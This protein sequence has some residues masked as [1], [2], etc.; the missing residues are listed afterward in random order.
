MSYQFTRSSMAAM[1]GSVACC[2]AIST[3][4]HAAGASMPQTAGSPPLAQQAPTATGPTLPTSTA[5]PAQL[6]AAEAASILALSTHLDSVYG[7][8]FG[9]PADGMLSIESFVPVP[10]VYLGSMDSED[11]FAIVVDIK[12]GIEA[13]TFE[14][15]MTL[16][17]IRGEVE[18][19]ALV[20]LDDAEGSAATVIPLDPANF[21]AMQLAAAGGAGGGGANQAAA[22]GQNP[23][24]QYDCQR[25]LG[26][27]CE[28]RRNFA[29]CTARNTHNLRLCGI[30][31]TLQAELR[32]AW[33]DFI[34]C[35]LLDAELNALLGVH[36]SLRRCLERGSPAAKLGCIV[37]LSGVSL[38]AAGYCLYRY[39]DAVADAED[40]AAAS[41]EREQ[42][43]YSMERAAIW[44]AYQNCPGATGDPVPDFPR[45]DERPQQVKTHVEIRP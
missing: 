28:A 32:D 35:L 37:F 36:V 17:T 14:A 6:A 40:A 18:T 20:A 22:G 9:T 11:F 10:G 41:V 5:S 33:E 16:K 23:C 27:S 44:A 2:L 1:V 31:Q 26:P 15:M 25:L 34:S 24:V 7:E 21:D 30:E 19:Y 12:P 13:S 39:N 8:L 42:E 45:R 38:G 4:E 29:L 3:V 43:I